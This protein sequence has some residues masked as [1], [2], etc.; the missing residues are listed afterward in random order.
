MLTH[1]IIGVR[2]GANGVHDDPTVA[3]LLRRDS[4]L[5]TEAQARTRQSVGVEDDSIS[6]SF[7]PV[8]LKR[9]PNATVHKCV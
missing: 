5:E 4:S 6:V 9:T 1:D 7:A 3:P 8:F 2:F